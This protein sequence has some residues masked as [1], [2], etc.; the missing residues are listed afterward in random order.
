MASRSIVVVTGV[1]MREATRSF[2]NTD[3]D[4]IVALE[5]TSYKLNAAAGAAVELGQRGH[6]VFTVGRDPHKLGLIQKY[7]MPSDS[8][9]DVVDLLDTAAVRAFADETGSIAESSGSTVHL[10]HYGGVSECTVPMPKGTIFLDPW[11]TPP[12]AIPEV[13][14]SNTVTCLNL[15]QAMKP[16]FRRQRQS[17]VVL[18]SAVAAMRTARLHGIDAIQKAAYH[19][20]ARTLALDLTKEN[21]YFTE[22]MPGMTDTGFY[23]SNETL[24]AVMEAAREYG[25]DYTEE[26]FPLFSARKVGQ[27]VSFAID[28]DAHVREISLVPYGQWPH[29]GA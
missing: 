13:V 27:A 25:Y 18:I 8:R 19:A 15:V 6:A 2:T 16:V 9:Y 5:G 7:L 17:K 22:V 4:D 21:I 24:G 12:T 11:D 20:M 10:V 29:L 23:D 26:T 28:T 3:T 1:N 14:E